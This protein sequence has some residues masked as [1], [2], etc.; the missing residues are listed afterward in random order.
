MVTGGTT[1]RDEG[2]AQHADATNILAEL[3]HSMKRYTEA[4]PYA[5]G[6]QQLPAR[7]RPQHPFTYSAAENL[8]K[9]LRGLGKKDEADEVHKKFGMSTP[10][11]G[12]G[13]AGE[14]GDG[15]DE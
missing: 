9:V 6:A 2:A 15:D 11:D 3:L 4:E 14:N 7:R 8:S 1:E 10:L 5:A 12:I 13:E